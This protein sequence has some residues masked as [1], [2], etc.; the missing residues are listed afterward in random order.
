MYI[1]IAGAGLVGRGL[2]ERLIAGRHDVVV[3]D[4]EGGVCDE[5]SAQTG[6]LVLSGNA[7]SIGILEE[8]GIRKADVAVGTMRSD[9]DNLAFS[10]LAKSYEVPRVIVRMRNPRYESAYRTAGVT[11][12][13]RVVDLFVDQLLLQVEEPDVR[14]VATFGQGRAAIVMVTLPES[15]VVDGQTVQQVAGDAAFPSDGVI[16]GIYRPAA[17]EFLFPRGSARLS[18]GDQVFLVAGRADL[19]KAAKFLHR[20][21]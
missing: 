19:R 8:A 7:T 12:T 6:A 18:A 2:A 15:A 4:R 5:V 17:A 10:L 16:T 9:A 11:T 20:R 1:V 14:Q 13:L 21:T 3:I